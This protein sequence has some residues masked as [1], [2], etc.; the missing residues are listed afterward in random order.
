M[1]DNRLP[2]KILNYK[3]EG[4]RNIGRSQTRWEDNFWQEGTGHGA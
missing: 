2:K 3:H 1:D 4:R